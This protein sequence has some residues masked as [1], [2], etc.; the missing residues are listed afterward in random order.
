MRALLYHLGTRRLTFLKDRGCSPSSKRSRPHPRP[1]RG[2]ERR[3]AAGPNAVRRVR[4]LRRRARQGHGGD[5]AQALQRPAYGRGG[6]ARHRAAHGGLADL[7]RALRERPRLLGPGCQTRVGAARLVCLLGLLGVSRR[8]GERD[9]RRLRR[10]H[11]GRR[12]RRL[13]VAGGRRR[14]A[15]EVRAFGR[16]GARTSRAVPCLVRAQAGVRHRRAPAGRAPSPVG[17][18]GDH[19]AVE[20]GADGRGAR[21][22]PLVGAGGGRLHG[23]RGADLPQARGRGVGRPRLTAGGAVGRVRRAAVAVADVV[24]EYATTQIDLDLPR[25]W[26]ARRLDDVSY[27]TGVWLSAVRGRS[28]ASLLPQLRK[29]ASTRR[30]TA[31]SSST[32][33][34]DASSSHSS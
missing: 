5:A 27:G 30:R 3:S 24:L 17:R 32:R 4:G 19:G 21:P 15:G 9:P 20:R 22:A 23:D 28:A 2:A 14:P 31:S 29:P 26:L 18:P 25:Y 8:A 7:D 16:R 11:A 34:A 10:E 6:A 13:R 12:G 33:S 1:G